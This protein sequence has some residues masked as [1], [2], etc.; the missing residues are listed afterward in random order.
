MCQEFGWNG[1]FWIPLVGWISSISV[2]WVFCECMDNLNWENYVKYE[3]INDEFN[4]MLK[5]FK[6]LGNYNSRVFLGKTNIN[7]V[8]IFTL[9]IKLKHQ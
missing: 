8:V 7:E 2:E 1:D 9:H 6:V 4:A 3:F 5:Y